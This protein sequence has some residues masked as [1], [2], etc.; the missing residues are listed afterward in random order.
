MIACRPTSWNAMFCAECRAAV[1]DRH[2]REHRF[3]IARG[4]LQHLHAAHRAA[5]HA[6][7]LLDAEMI[8]QQLLRPHHVADRDDRKIER[9]RLAGR[10]VDLL[11]AGGAHAAAEHIGADQEIALGVEHVAGPDQRGPPPGMA[12]D[13]VR[14]GDVL[15]AGQRVAD[16]DRVAALGVERAVGLIG[17]RERRRDRR[18]NRAAS[19]SRR[20]ACVRANRSGPV[21]GRRKRG[22][23]KID[24]RRSGS[25]KGLEPS[26]APP[27]GRPCRK[28]GT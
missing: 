21:P 12:G 24:K 20:R 4:P 15:V 6:E 25:G 18:R 9:P 2:R 3:G 17:D 23:V 1:G 22:A 27:R 8:D 26:P 19:A 28:A 7:Q 10:R 14:V 16:Q 13:R 5:D 11:R